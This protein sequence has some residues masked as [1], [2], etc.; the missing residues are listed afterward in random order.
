[1]R[2]LLPVRCKG[3]RTLNRSR[4]RR[5]T[6]CVVTLFCEISRRR[7]RPHTPRRPPAARRTV[8]AGLAGLA[9]H[10]LRGCPSPGKFSLLSSP[11]SVTGVTPL[12]ACA[13]STS[14]A[15]RR[16]QRHGRPRPLPLWTAHTS[17]SFAYNPRA[18]LHL[19]TRARSTAR[20]SNSHA[21][22]C[23][24]PSPSHQRRLRS[25]PAATPSTAASIRLCDCA[26]AV[27]A[28][29]AARSSTTRRSSPPPAR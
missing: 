12:P 29:A 3:A 11:L 26:C 14:P 8:S 18:P 6:Y 16:P 1:M 27:A 24:I 2:A 23:V 15:A 4:R 28:A 20:R 5:L 13:E 10:P 22:P 7:R 17:S 19:A 25:S 21:A 9:L